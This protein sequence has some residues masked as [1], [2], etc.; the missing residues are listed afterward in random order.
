MFEAADLRQALNTLGALL[1][2]RG[3]SFELVAIGGGGLLLLE[4]IERPT[5]DLDALALVENGDYKYARPLPAALAEAV[6][7]TAGVLGLAPDWLNSGPADQGI[8]GFLTAS[9]IGR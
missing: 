3:H 1:E 8:Q 5:K 2:D 6:A 7:D 9:A 4:I